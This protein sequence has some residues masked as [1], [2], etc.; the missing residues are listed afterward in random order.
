MCMFV[1]S[2]TMMSMQALIAY[3]D[4][5]ILVVSVTFQDPQSALEFSRCLA[6]IIDT[7]RNLSGFAGE[8]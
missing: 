4:R 5:I 2:A 1:A 6:E 7:S 8:F 3:Y